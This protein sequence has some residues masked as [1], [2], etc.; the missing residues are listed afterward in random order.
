LSAC[1]DHHVGQPEMTPGNFVGESMR[2]SRTNF[3]FGHGTSLRFQN[4]SM[5]GRKVPEPGFGE[6]NP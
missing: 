4:K 1:I 2:F 6:E 5:T 3:P